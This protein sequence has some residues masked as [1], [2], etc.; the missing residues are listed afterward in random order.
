MTYVAE[1][2]PLTERRKSL[3]SQW[4]ITEQKL[5]KQSA[6]NVMWRAGM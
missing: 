4:M 2:W 6:A 3:K 1:K 5:T